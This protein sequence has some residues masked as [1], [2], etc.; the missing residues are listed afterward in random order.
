MLLH[1]FINLTDAPEEDVVDEAPASAGLTRLELNGVEIHSL[2]ELLNAGK[3]TIY[4]CANRFT[5]PIRKSGV[6]YI[7]IGNPKMDVLFTEEQYRPAGITF[8][9]VSLP[10]TLASEAADSQWLNNIDA[11]YRNLCDNIKSSKKVYI[12]L[13]LTFFNFPKLEHFITY[14]GSVAFSLSLSH[15][16]LVH[17]VLP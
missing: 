10:A 1:D 3:S 12:P 17:V 5:V 11:L 7:G 14:L 6:H 9:G 8:E 13:A 15:E 4:L 2:A 16:H